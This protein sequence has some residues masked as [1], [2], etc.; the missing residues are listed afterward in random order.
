MPG[1]WP[2]PLVT[3]AP[4]MT[5]AAPASAPDLAVALRT[6]ARPFTSRDATLMPRTW[7]PGTLPGG[8]PNAQ[9]R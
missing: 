2:W 6:Q 9:G 5:A 4:L 3:A 1:A 8:T 7:R